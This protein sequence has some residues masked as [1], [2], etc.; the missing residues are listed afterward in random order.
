MSPS[1]GVSTHNRFRI[2]ANRT[3]VLFADYILEHLTPG[4][5]AGFIVPEGIIFQNNDD[6]VALRK[7]LINEAGLWAVVSLPAQIFQPYSGV[8]TSVLLI[9]RALARTRNDVLLVKVESDGFSLNTNRNPIAENDLPDAF[10][11]LT[12]ARRADYAAQ[13]AAMQSPLQVECKL[14]PSSMLQNG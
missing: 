3:E 1:G 12:T 11:L 7:W 14:I 2:A 8:K 9:D 5:K 6:Y 13:L 10:K 4:G